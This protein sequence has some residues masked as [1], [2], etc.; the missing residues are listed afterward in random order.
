M[1]LIY[2]TRVFLIRFAKVFPFILSAVVCIS[3]TESIFSLLNESYMSL[4]GSVVLC[5]PISHALGGLFVYDWYTI[6]VATVLSF[7]FETCWYN[8]ACI[9]YL[10]INAWERDYFLTVELYPEYIYAICTANIIVSGYLTF[11]GIKILL[12]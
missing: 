2:K 4:D 1:N 11:K 6:I 5:K 3:Y 12:K 9:V 8:K 10:C 7:A